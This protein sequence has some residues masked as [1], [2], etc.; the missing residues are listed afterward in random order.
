MGGEADGWIA[1]VQRVPGEASPR[2][3]ELGIRPVIL[4][5]EAALQVV[6]PEALAEQAVAALEVGF[7][8]VFVVQ[9]QDFIGLG[10]HDMPGRR[11]EMAARGEIGFLDRFRSNRDNLFMS[12]VGMPV[13]RVFA[14][15]ASAAGAAPETMSKPRAG[16]A[17]APAAA[18]RAR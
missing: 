15:I 2:K 18:H 6:F 1:V 10:K 8:D 14:R 12:E 4:L 16:I 11:G 13:R 17:V 9:E 5:A 3:V 7:V